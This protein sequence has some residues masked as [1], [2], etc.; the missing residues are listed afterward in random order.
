M[1]PYTYNCLGKAAMSFSNVT[2]LLLEVAN[3]DVDFRLVDS[4][5]HLLRPQDDLVSSTRLS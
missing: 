3:G 4:Q 1:N 5:G 2:E